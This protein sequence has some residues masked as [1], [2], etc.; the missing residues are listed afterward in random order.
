M[1]G[2]TSFFCAVHTSYLD[3]NFRSHFPLF[4]WRCACSMTEEMKRPLLSNFGFGSSAPEGD[5]NR[6]IPVYSDADPMDIKRLQENYPKNIIVSSRYTIINFFPKSLLEQFRRLANVYF[7]VIGLIALVGYYTNDYET[8]VQPAGILGP[9]MIV[10]LI[11]VIKD[12]VEDVKRHRADHAINTR[13]TR[14]TDATGRIEQVEWQD[15]KTGDMLL[16]FA[17]EE[18]PADCVVLT[19]GGIQGP[20]CYVETAAIDGETNLKM[21]L[22]AFAIDPSQGNRT[23]YTISKDKTSI[24]GPLASLRYSIL[25]LPLYSSPFLISSFRFF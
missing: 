13:S 8:A 23:D 1:S 9:V 10:V 14:R 17:D 19:C 24:S 16:I 18:I 7:L 5:G 11:S 20:I 3:S 6:T 22:P 12:G 21:K 15:I 2:L 4:I 25:Y